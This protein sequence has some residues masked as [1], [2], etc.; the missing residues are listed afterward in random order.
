MSS[1]ILVTGGNGPSEARWFA[2]ALAERLAVEFA[3]VL[4]WQAGRALGLGVA[5][6]ALDGWRGTHALVWKTGRGRKR[7][8]VGVAV[9]AP[10]AEVPAMDPRDVVVTAMRAGGPGGQCVNTTISAVLARHLPTGLVVR[11]QDERS[12][13]ANRRMAL[14]R[15]AEALAASTRATEA[16]RDRSQWL[17]HHTLVRGEPVAEWG[18][19]GR[20]RLSRR[21]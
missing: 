3:S 18:R 17:V 11:V 12:Q 15:L 14:E 8:F 16:A 21:G 4:A 2:D 10:P 19:D 5:P 7:W 1:E 13:H 9:F 20:G 6:S